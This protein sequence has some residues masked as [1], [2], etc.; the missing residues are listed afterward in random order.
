MLSLYSVMPCE[1]HLE[2]ALHVFSYL[3]SKSNSRLIFDSM[4]PNVGDSNFVECDWSEFYLG[5]SEAL[6]PDAPKPLRKGVT[7]R[8]FLDS[9]YAGDKVIR[10]S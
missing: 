7:P 1:G 5:A 2:A 10:C 6:L 9:N 8:M 3:K 4:E